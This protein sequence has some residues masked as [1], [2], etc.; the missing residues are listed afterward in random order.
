MPTPHDPE[1]GKDPQFDDEI[2]G[3]DTLPEIEIELEDDE[4]D[5]T[6]RDPDEDEDR[7]ETEV[8]LDEIEGPDA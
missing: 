7:E 2:D 1:Q 6:S 3:E 4:H 5:K 8:E